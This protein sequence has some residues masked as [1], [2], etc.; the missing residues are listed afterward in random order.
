MY[1][2]SKAPNCMLY[3]LVFFA[4]GVLY[5]RKSKIVFNQSQK[6][7]PKFVDKIQKPK[8]FNEPRNSK[9]KRNSFGHQ[10]NV[11]ICISGKN[12]IEYFIKFSVINHNL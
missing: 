9:C 1:N 8:P 5:K 12:F 7:F 2:Y 10:F 11:S 3:D 4:I 6:R